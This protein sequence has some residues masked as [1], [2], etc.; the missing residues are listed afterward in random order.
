[1]TSSRVG[2]YHFALE[3]DSWSI[4]HLIMPQIIH[5]PK[6]WVREVSK[7]SEVPSEVFGVVSSKRHASNQR[8]CLFLRSNQFSSQE[9]FASHF[10]KFWVNDVAGNDETLR[11][12]EYFR[13]PYHFSLNG[14]PPQDFFNAVFVWYNFLNQQHFRPYWDD[15][16]GVGIQ[17]MRDFYP[18]HDLRLLHGFT[19]PLPALVQQLPPPK[20]IRDSRTKDVYLG[21]PISLANHACSKHSNCVLNLN[22]GVRLGADIFIMSGQRVYICYSSDEEEIARTRGFRCAVCVR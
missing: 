11:F 22:D 1:M 6:D 17:V 7:R 9:E 21:G 10:L 20:L 16:E 8:F 19:V 12:S 2:Q 5:D 3:I 18:P 4:A 13:I 14:V 15:V